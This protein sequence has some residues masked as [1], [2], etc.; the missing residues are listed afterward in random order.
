[1]VKRAHRTVLGSPLRYVWQ[2]VS[3]QAGPCWGGGVGAAG[4][5]LWPTLACR[6]CSGNAVMPNDEGGEVVGRPWGRL[7]AAGGEGA[8]PA[9]RTTAWARG[10]YIA[11]L[12]MHGERGGAVVERCFG[13]VVDALVGEE[14]R[15]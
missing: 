11:P 12:Q 5:Y 15:R 3:T 13:C 8:P 1:M 10:K 4:P 6:P 14:A 2:A 7:Y 9:R